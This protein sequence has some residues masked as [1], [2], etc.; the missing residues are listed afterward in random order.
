[1]ANS[2]VDDDFPTES[3]QAAAPLA[4]LKRRIGWIDRSLL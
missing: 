3:L 1:M 4:R 2:D